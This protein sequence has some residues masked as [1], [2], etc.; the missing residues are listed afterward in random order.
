MKK[1]IL[2]LACFCSISLFGQ[3]NTNKPVESFEKF[4]HFFDENYAS[5]EE[6]NIDWNFQYKKNRAFITEKTPDT[7]LFRIFKSMLTDFKD[8]HVNLRAPSIDSFYNAGRKSL[9]L[10]RLGPIPGRE[11]RARFNEMTE[12]TLLKEGFKKLKFIGPEYKGRAL[13][14]YTDNGKIG[15]LRYT[16]SFSSHDFMNLSLTNTLLNQI[17]KSFQNLEGL[18]LDVRFNIG[19]DTSFTNN[20][21]GRFLK[22]RILG[23]Y[24]QQRKRG[25]FANKKENYFG[26]RGRYQF[27][28]KPVAVLLN[29]QTVSAADELTLVLKELPNVTLIG[30]PSNGSYSNMESK[31][32]PNGWVTTLSYQ[33]YFDA[34]GVNYEGLGTPVDIE[35]KNTLQDVE[36][37]SD[38]VL[39][40]AILH[41]SKQ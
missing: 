7:T 25:R 14:T 24:K 29:D 21:L 38:S 27:L 22:E 6:K 12:T 35:V 19:G 11:R 16:R 33:R 20:V 40:R 9:I 18:V 31:K 13:F 8:D 1:Y 41:L 30:E 15:Y 39:N 32:L 23:N 4:W 37:K 10:E 28:D 2:L 3:I 17:F 36:N 26:P 5:F 34:H